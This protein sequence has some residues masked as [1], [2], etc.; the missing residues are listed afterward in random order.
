MEEAV[1]ERVS[2]VPTGEEERK[3]NWEYLYE[4]VKDFP[5]G[6]VFSYEE[7]KKTTGFSRSKI[8]GLIKK[9]NRELRENHQKSLVNMPDYGYKIGTPDE[10]IRQGKK[11][12]LKGNRQISRA[13]HIVEN[14]DTSDFTQEQKER[15]VH[16]LNHLS[17]K[18]KIARKKN[19][20]SL[21]HTQK[22]KQNIER[23]EQAQKKNLEQIE[24]MEK[25]LQK[26]KKKLSD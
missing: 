3:F 19:V 9:T 8:Q 6:T 17:S 13:Q 12:E 20:E 25:E 23:S 18:N 2:P 4:V 15:W 7:L 11:H 1:D 22:A 10:Q 16:Y 26:M 14:M 21:E 5:H 24:E